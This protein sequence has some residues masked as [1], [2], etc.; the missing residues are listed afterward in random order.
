MCGGAE[1]LVS[2]VTPVYNGEL[3]L[4]EC[5]ESVLAQT[6]SNWEYLILNNASTDDTLAIAE[7]YARHDSRIRVIDC[8]ELLPI[9]AN[10]NRAF[11]HISGE[12]RYCK[13]VSAD[14][15]IYPECLQKMVALAEAHPAIGIVGAYQLAGGKDIWYVRNVGLSYSQSVVPG[16]DICRAHLCGTLRVLGNPTS[17]LYRADLVRGSDAFF[18]NATHE[19]DISAC[20]EH[21]RY[22]NFG[23]V[24]QILTHERIHSDRATTSS[25]ENNAYVSAEISDCQAYGDWYLSRQEKAERIEELLNEYY[26]YLSASAFK[27]KGKD[28]WAYHIERL[29]QLGYRFD[30]WK[31]GKGVAVKMMASLLNPKGT[32][33]AISR[34]I[35]LYALLRGA[36]A[37]PKGS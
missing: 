33:Q 25:L 30:A 32:A 19:A 14:D 28:F 36:R 6:Y 8:D 31:L 3:Y 22:D 17:V 15:W 34:H 18:P 16:R 29:D 5:I 10:H 1:P 4:R 9:I 26:G 12:S 11:R 13:V 23:F 20:V 2:V 35:R 7:D 37:N 27:M 21:L 24:H